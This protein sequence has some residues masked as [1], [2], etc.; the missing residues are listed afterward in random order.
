MP[1]LAGIA[2]RMIALDLGEVLVEGL[3]NTVLHDPGVIASYLGDTQSVIDR[4][5]PSGAIGPNTGVLAAAGDRHH[6]DDVE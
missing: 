4:S 6:P 1:L 2:D 3:P 5:G